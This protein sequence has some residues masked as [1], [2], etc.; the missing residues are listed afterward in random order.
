[1]SKSDIDGIGTQLGG[2]C[3]VLRLMEMLMML[4]LLVVNVIGQSVQGIPAAR[5]I[6]HVVHGGVLQIVLVLKLLQGGAH[7]GRA[8][9]HE[10][11]VLRLL[12]RVHGVRERCG[13]IGEVLLLDG[14]VGAGYEARVGA[15][16]LFLLLIDELLLLLLLWNALVL[17]D[18]R[19]FFAR[20]V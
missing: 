20:L 19:V 17:L 8:G 11:Q 16:V 7:A 2:H 14:R 15:H 9:V 10:R 6:L 3:C 1:M 18:W 5:P 4:L 12:R 13:R